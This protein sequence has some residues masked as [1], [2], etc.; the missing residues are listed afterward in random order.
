MS[1]RVDPEQTP[2]AISK[3]AP[4]LVLAALVTIQVLFGVNYLVSKVVVDHFPP[5]L[6][7]S[8]R[9]I[10]SAVIMI[11]VALFSR[12]VHPKG[13]AE[14]F[15][16]LVI[17]A[18]L[19]MI[20]NQSSFLV[21]LHYTTPT[22]SAILTTLIPIFTLLIVTIR[23]QE[24]VTLIRVLGFLSALTGVLVLRG[25]ENFSFSDRTFI[26]DLLTILNCLSFALFLSYSKPFLA[27]HDRVWTTAWLFAYGSLGI[28]LIA[29]PD[30]ISF[31]MPVMTPALWGAAAFAILGGTLFTYFLNNWA[32]AHAKSSHVALF[33]YIQP[34]VAALAAWIW[35][36]EVI[37][38]RTLASMVLIFSGMIMGLG[39]EMLMPKGATVE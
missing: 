15:G 28:T 27:K 4:F 26:G 7:A 8:A 3:P 23:G 20:I 31:E 13:G 18:L 37:T 32:L 22:N 29:I 12:R 39:R 38:F 2:M 9:I 25:I 34:V 14:F 5:L 21:G 36:G 6:W 17:F 11:S 19:G 35:K 16:P 30:W 10:I 24:P 33:V 1:D